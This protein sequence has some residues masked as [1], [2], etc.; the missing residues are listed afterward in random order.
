M[1]V[2]QH[3][4]D[5]ERVERI[6]GY[7]S[8]ET[9]EK[10]LIGQWMDRVWQTVVLGQLVHG[11]LKEVNY[12]CDVYFTLEVPHGK[13]TLYVK[14]P[15]EEFLPAGENANGEICR[16]LPVVPEDHL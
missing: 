5:W 9:A 8:R 16:V 6:Q 15:F 1:T 2:H 4:A 14:G 13:K 3:M 10:Q 7:S 11:K 12:A